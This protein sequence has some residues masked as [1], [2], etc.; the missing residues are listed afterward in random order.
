MERNRMLSWTQTQEE[1]ERMMEGFNSSE[2][3]AA[4]P[5]VSQHADAPEQVHF[6]RKGDTYSIR[7]SWKAQDPSVMQVESMEF[8]DQNL[9]YL[10][11]INAKEGSDSVAFTHSG[12]TYIARRTTLKVA[13]RLLAYANKV[14]ECVSKVVG[15]LKTLAGSIYLISRV[16]KATWS[17]D[18]TLSA[19]HLQ[20]A[21]WQDFDSTHKGRFAELATEMMVK[22]HKSGHL[23]SNPVPSEIMLDSKKAFV[24]D[25]R[26]IRPARRPHD[27]VDNFILMLRGLMLRGVDSNG[28]LFYCLSMYV[29]SMEEECRAWYKKN[30]RS[31]PADLFQVAQELESRVAA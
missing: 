14:G 29:N 31:T 30:K 22:L 8:S 2:S 4:I 20:G 16:E 15:Y 13:K 17:L 6:K 24:A 7:Y 1:V 19:P 25:P 9:R 18:S 27:A 3:T 12:F 5:D 28:T 10:H 23:F 11:I 21:S 26:D